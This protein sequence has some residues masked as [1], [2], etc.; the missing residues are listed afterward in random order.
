[1]SQMYEHD[2]TW[3]TINRQRSVLWL[4]QSF[5]LNNTSSSLLI[6]YLAQMAEFCHLI[7]FNFTLLSRYTCLGMGIAM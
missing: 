2:T 7:A 5:C 3:G 6:W 1:M 4:H